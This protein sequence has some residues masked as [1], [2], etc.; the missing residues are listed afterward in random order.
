[1]TL[2]NTIVTSYVFY[3]YSNISDNSD[4][5]FKAEQENIRANGR[6]D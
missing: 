4:Y 5:Y 3:T 2:L 1:M 6:A